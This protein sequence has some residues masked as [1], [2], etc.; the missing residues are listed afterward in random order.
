MIPGYNSDSNIDNNNQQQHNTQHRNGTHRSSQRP[1][2]RLHGSEAHADAL[3]LTT[4]MSLNF[5]AAPLPS[6]RAVQR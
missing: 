4:L 6:P 1:P 3:K 5:V 2:P